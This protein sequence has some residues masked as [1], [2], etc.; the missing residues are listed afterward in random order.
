M[1]QILR[2]LGLASGMQLRPCSLAPEV[3]NR[4][5]VLLSLITR[6]SYVSLTTSLLAARSS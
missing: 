4:D 3:G 1:P 6:N 5:S 2:T